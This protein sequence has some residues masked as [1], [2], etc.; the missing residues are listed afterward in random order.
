M[1]FL[2]VAAELAAANS[3]KE[4]NFPRLAKKSVKTPIELATHSEQMDKELTIALGK[5]SIKEINQKDTVELFTNLEFRS[6]FFK[7]D[8]GAVVVDYSQRKDFRANGRV[9]DFS[10]RRDALLLGCPYSSRIGQLYGAMTTAAIN[11]Q[12]ISAVYSTQNAVETT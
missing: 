5:Y 8:N 2:E 12:L 10:H 1:A 3:I 4:D 9:L 7:I 6:R 11:S